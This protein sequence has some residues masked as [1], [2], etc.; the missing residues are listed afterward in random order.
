MG[1]ACSTTTFWD[2]DSNGLY[3][4][5]RHFKE[6]FYIINIKRKMQKKSARLRNIAPWC[7]LP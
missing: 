7:V 5:K 3:G 4:K 1:N 2:L 6:L